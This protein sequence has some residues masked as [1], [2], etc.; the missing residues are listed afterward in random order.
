[1]GRSPGINSIPAEVY[2]YG[3]A[4]RDERDSTTRPP[5]C[6]HSFPVQ[7]QWTEIRLFKLQRHHPILHCRP[8]SGSRLAEDADPDDGKGNTSASVG[9]EPTWGLQI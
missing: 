8:N 9:S 1:M 5:G 3:G 6:S 7:E 2:Q 4:V